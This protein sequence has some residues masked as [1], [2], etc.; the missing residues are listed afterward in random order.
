MRKYLLILFFVA[1]AAVVNAQVPLMIVERAGE[2]PVR[3]SDLE[4]RVRIFGHLAETTMTMKFYNPNSRVLEGELEFP[5]P[6][7]AI[8]SGYAL[9]VNGD[10]VEGVAVEKQKAREIFETEVRKGVD[11]G[12]VEKVKG[13]NFKTR[14]YPLSPRGIRTVQ[15]IYLT[16]LAIDDASARY[17]VPLQLSKATD[18]FNLR[19]EVLSADE[20][21]EIEIQ[22]LQPSEFKQVKS[23][24]FSEL[25][26]NKQE[27]KSELLVDVPLPE[28]GAVFVEK[29]ADGQFYFSVQGVVANRSGSSAKEAQRIVVL[30]DASG[31]AAKRDLEL[32][33]KFLTSLLASDRVAGQF[34]VEFVEFR[35]KPGKAVSFSLK[36]GDPAALLKHVDSIRF[37]G[38][39]SFTGLAAEIKKP[40]FYLL[41][42]DGLNTFGRATMPEF[43]A[44]VYA[45]CSADG[46]D[47][48]FLQTVCRKSGGSMINLKNVELERA[49]KLIG[50]DF[51]GLVSRKAGAGLAE[52]YPAGVVPVH[53]RFMLAGVLEGAEA[54]LL[55]QFGGHSTEKTDRQFTIKKSAAV[56]GEFLRKFWAGR[57]I[58]DL[59]A[60]KDKNRG[61]IVA[62]SKKHSIANEFTSLLVL[63]R[64]EQYLEH[65][66]VPP[67]SKPEWR[68][69]YFDVLEKEAAEL[70]KTRD[71]KLESIVSMWTERLKWWDTDFSKVEPQKFN[72]KGDAMAPGS[73]SRSRDME[74]LGG[75]APEPESVSVSDNFSGSAQDDGGV[76]APQEMREMSAPSQLSG[77]MESSK[78]MDLDESKPVGASK[79]V[80]PGVAIKPW[81]PNTP[82]VKK[83]KAAKEP[84]SAYL[85][86]KAEYQMSP[87]FYLD[88]ADVFIAL[89]M[90]DTALQVLSNIAELELENPALMRILAHRLSQIE[91]LA[92]SAAIFEEVLEMRKEEP[93]SYRDLA[94]VLGRM[95]E[96]Q[97]AVELLY[98]VVLKQWDGRFPEIEVIALEEMNNLI[99]QGK[100]NGIK[101]YKVDE[102]LMKPIDVDLRIVMTWDADQTDM[103]LWV[104]EPSGEKAF[105][106]NPRTQIGGL[107]SRDFTQGYGPEEYMIRHARH[108]MYEIKTNFF[109]SRS[110]K[111]A[112][113]VTLQV[114]LFT[115]F[116]RE[117][118]KRRSVTLRLTENKETFTVA[119][120]E[121]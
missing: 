7:G 112:G 117:N 121:F 118:E 32:E 94:L 63:E 49:V 83:I 37:D 14:V 22:G 10:L 19:V 58:D 93:Q 31:S 29:S 81:E 84:Y 101:D 56:S 54:E 59:F 30:Y 92:I 106:S 108:G 61:E 70:T 100:R 102:R 73:P 55:L 62:L 53:P 72:K 103:D 28:A 35:N 36:R 109:G 8:V 67:A 91:E 44:P 60:Q 9:D 17:R 21:P 69:Q 68:K 77:A 3:L 64:I 113:A 71:G 5:M 42:S 39:T 120:I 18:R 79:P 65:R 11:P 6:E 48:G 80:N 4:M 76:M 1:L 13:N 78:S 12:L 82:Y 43:N 96:Y 115:N 27:I 87:A 38:G 119:D 66:V 34:E 33:K 24:W 20:K 114:D 16:E 116:G 85:E 23:G 57:K 105:Y 41:L 25:T 50:A 99:V 90:N 40:D 74:T 111:V 47:Y 110:Q 107:V 104:M 46:A 15:V 51:F 45:V 52:I 88:C 26:V 86:E 98:E 97:R 89:K 2:E 95:S 75:S